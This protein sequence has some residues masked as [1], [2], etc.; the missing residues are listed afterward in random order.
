MFV[1]TLLGAMAMLAAAGPAAQEDFASTAALLNEIR[2]R[3][4][5]S[6]PGVEQALR[7]DQRLDAV[8]RRIAQAEDFDSALSVS[9]YRASNATVLHIEA[10][11]GPSGVQR[12]LETTFCDAVADRRFQD[13]GTA[14]RSQEV[15]I[16]LAAP[17]EFIDTLDPATLAARVLDLTNRARART[18]H[19]GA[20]TFPP[21]APLTALPELDRVA[22]AHADDMAARRTLTHLGRDGSNV[23]ERVTRA[24][25]ASRAVAENI[26]EGQPD[27]FIV[28]RRWLE[29]PD[30]CANLMGPDYTRMGVAYA[31][32]DQ[33]TGQSYWVQI[34]AAPR[35]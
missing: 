31:V 27:A 3:G 20:T 25:Y 1:R 32:S 7:T 13:L 8:A 2:A 35:D 24:G 22:Q 29:S 6:R 10:Q 5:G 30:H 12:L 26:A 4:C 17:L 34:L 33:A 15:W 9:G 23:R 21:A 18:Q 16:V 28:V 19:C 14:H 11:S